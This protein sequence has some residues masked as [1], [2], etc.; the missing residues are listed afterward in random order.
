MEGADIERISETLLL[1]L[2]TG[3]PARRIADLDL[4]TAH[5]IAERVRALREARGEHVVRAEDRLHQHLAAFA[6]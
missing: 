2:D 3:R 1:S 4:A 5:R 6:A